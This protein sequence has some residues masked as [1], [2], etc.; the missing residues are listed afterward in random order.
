MVHMRGFGVTFLIAERRFGFG[1]ARRAVERGRTVFGNVSAA[2]GVAAS[3]MTA[4]LRPNGPAPR[5]QG[6]GQENN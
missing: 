6:K 1:G 5:E 3:A 2:Y 4:M